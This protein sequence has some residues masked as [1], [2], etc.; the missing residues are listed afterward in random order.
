MSA[1]ARSLVLSDSGGLQ[2]EVTA[3]SIGKFCVVLRTSTEAVEAG[4]ARVMGFEKGAIC[5]EMEARAGKGR[6]SQEHPYGTGDA[7][8]RIIDALIP[9][10][11]RRPCPSR[12]IGP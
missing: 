2:E 6:P 8:K 11:A 5:A 1:D 4:H 7:A 9:A 12:G 10:H 3:P